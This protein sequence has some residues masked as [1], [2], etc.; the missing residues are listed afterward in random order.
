MATALLV[1]RDEADR[2]PA[3]IAE[4]QRMLKESTSYYW[5]NDGD[6]LKTILQEDTPEYAFATWQAERQRPVL[7][8][9]SEG[10][11]QAL[12]ALWDAAVMVGD[13]T[14]APLLEDVLF[15]AE[16]SS[17]ENRQTVSI[18]VVDDALHRAALYALEQG[19]VESGFVDISITYLPPSGLA[20]AIVADEYDI[21]ESSPLLVATG[22][23]EG[24]DLM[25]LSG[26]TEDLDS[27]LL[28]GE[29]E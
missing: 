17:D 24:L 21:V 25:V 23:S 6:V 20:E 12:K 2:R 27:T 10:T 29:A 18:A 15:H 13:I 22:E 3:A 11:Q 16:G 4:A 28:F 14:T 1:H 19:L 9:V 5:A 7:G 26:G 8:D